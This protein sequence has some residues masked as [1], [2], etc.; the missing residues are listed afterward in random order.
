[1]ILFPEKFDR[2]LTYYLSGPMSGYKN[3]NYDA[4]DRATRTFRYTGLSIESPHENPS[5]EGANE[6]EPG[7]LWKHMM[8]LCMEQMERCSGIILLPGFYR[9]SG[10]MIELG[11]ARN[12][13]WPA[14]FLAQHFRLVDLVDHEKVPA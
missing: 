9:S 14:Y 5:P 2:G 6:M 13:K 11:V 8:G 1:M 4:F 7:A 12:K 10:A 3:Y